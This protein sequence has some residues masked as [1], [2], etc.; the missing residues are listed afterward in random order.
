MP[1]S[2]LLTII[3]IAASPGGDTLPLPRLERGQ[4][5][6]F[7]GEIVDEC[8]RPGQVYRNVYELNV[9]WLVL[10]TSDRRTDLAILTSVTPRSDPK[11]VAAA[12]TVSG[13]VAVKAKASV[14]VDLVR[15][16]TNGSMRWLT[17]PTSPPPF[18]LA[19]DHR[20]NPLPTFPLS[21][22][23]FNEWGL[24][25]PQ[26]LGRDD[27]DREW[28]READS[29]WNGSRV[30]DLVSV[31][32]SKDFDRLAASVVG[33]RRIERQFISPTDGLPRAY[34]RRIEQ[35][36][37][38]SIVTTMDVRMEMK[39]PVPPGDAISIRHVRREAEMAAWFAAEWERFRSEGNK[40]DPK[41]AHV[42][43]AR[44]ERYLAEYQSP[45]AFRP[46]VEAVAKQVRD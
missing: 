17:I 21:G 29:M 11:I 39:A 38:K 23:A 6:P 34:V 19:P 7:V 40:L 13:E 25:S 43:K 2:L 5:I 28:T 33:W 3:A 31:R 15:V 18:S 44:I 12:K 27:G 20:S 36:E 35:R 4:E 30:L 26:K 8:K 42:L 16:E 14:R 46:A 24:I 45:T 22:P 41:A 1:V 10:E 32:T 37:G 9:R